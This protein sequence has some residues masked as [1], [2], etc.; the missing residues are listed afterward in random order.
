MVLYDPD[1]GHEHVSLTICSQTVSVKKLRWF[2]SPTQFKSDR[3]EFLRTDESFRSFLI[4]S[5][6]KLKEK[7]VDV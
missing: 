5:S 2:Q 1:G 3:T 7:V 6:C 4:V